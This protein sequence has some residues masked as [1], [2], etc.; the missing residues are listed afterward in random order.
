MKRLQSDPQNTTRS[1]IFTMLFAAVIGAMAY[2]A[3][4]V[5]EWLR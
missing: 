5:G 1:T 3:I 4:P 2:T